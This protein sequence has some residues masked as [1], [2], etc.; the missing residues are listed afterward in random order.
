MPSSVISD[1][2]LVS[3]A[4]FTDTDS[5]VALWLRIVGPVSSTRRDLIHALVAGLKSDGVWTKLDRLW[6]LAAENQQT[7]LVDL[8][9]RVTATIAGA[10]TFSANNGYTATSP[11]FNGINTGF[12]ASTAGGNY[13]QNSA[14]LAAWC[15]TNAQSNETIASYGSIGAGA[16]ENIYPRYT[17]D[18]AYTRVNDNPDSSGLTNT[19]ALG[20]Y[21]GNR[22]SS[23]TRQS[24]K[25]GASLGSLGT[26]NS[27]APVNDTFRFATSGTQQCSAFHCGGSLTGTEVTNLYNR[28]R[29]YMTAVG[30]P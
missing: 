17:D 3:A 10:V 14:H 27:Q 19:N 29:T 7:A 6:I 2:V 30:V 23:T 9:A 22:D 18:N 20:D 12:N 24:Y 11:N 25:N 21:L 15:N 28:I 26:V 1:N 16:G 8:K 4:G 5:D 13:T